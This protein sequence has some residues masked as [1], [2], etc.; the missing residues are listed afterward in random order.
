MVAG[1]SGPLLTVQQ[2]SLQHTHIVQLHSFHQ[3]CGARVCCVSGSMGSI[4]SSLDCSGA[5][6]RALVAVAAEMGL[7]TVYFLLVAVHFLQGRLQLVL[8][9]VMRLLRWQ[10]FK[11]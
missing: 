6:R 5:A 4:W 10:I 8:L 11:R 3:S 9:L 2:S 1:C 7:Q